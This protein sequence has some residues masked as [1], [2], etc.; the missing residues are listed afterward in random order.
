MQNWISRGVVFA[1]LLACAA[2]ADV[3]TFTVDTSKKGAVLPNT[4]QMLTSWNVPKPVDLNTLTNRTWD[5]RTFAEWVEIMAATGGNA[6]RDCYR[7]PN[8]RAVTDDYDFTRLV[9]GCRYILALGMKPYLKLGNV[10]MK[11]SSNISNG[12]F[13]MNVRPPDDAAVYARYMEACAQALLAAFGR[14]ELLKWRFAV[15][16]EYENGGWFKDASGDPE[17]TFQA[18]CLLYEK[19]VEAFTRVISPKLSFGVHA[20]GVTEG[21]WDERRFFAF[22]AVRHL[23]L[24]FVSTSFYDTRPGVFTR[25]LT[26]PKTIAHLREAAE[27]AGLKNLRY[28][29]DEGRILDGVHG[30]S[31]RRDLTLRIVGDTYQA[32]YD[33]RIVRQL[34]D[35]GAEYFSAWGYLS[36]PN[37]WFDGVPSVSFYVAREAAAFKG[38]NRL[39]VVASGAAPVGVEADAVAALAPDAQAL[40]VMAYAFTND[41]YAAGTT[42]LA[43]QLKLPSA[44]KGRA[45]EITR[46]QID[47]NSNWFDEWRADRQRLGIPDKAF[48]W[49]SDDPSTLSNWGLSN[50]ANRKQFITELLPR[51]RRCAQLKP[52]V[53]RTDPPADG[54][55]PL[56]YDVPFNATLFLTVK[57]VSAPSSL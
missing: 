35:S 52:E 23:P 27:K 7:D 24:A 17:R 33:A 48:L 30:G 22:A 53:R 51:Y 49:S 38:M 11:L 31:A 1:S 13:S 36:G 20:M 39:D 54:V 16:T 18:Y 21:L 42:R 44:W 29:V 47:D 3:R 28:G 5:V 6:Q 55:L 15:L 50:E 56:A 45:V 14:E 8:N 25:G 43:F 9:K 40:K 2:G 46:V 57:P 19:T 34:F 37:T 26:L 4:A 12:D 32:A 10:P 41:L